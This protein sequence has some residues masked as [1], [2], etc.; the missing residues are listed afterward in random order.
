MLLEPIGVPSNI[1]VK[2]SLT[3]GGMERIE[4]LA[5]ARNALLPTVGASLPRTASTPAP[6]K[7][8]RNLTADTAGTGVNAKAGNNNTV[9]RNWE[10]A[11]SAPVQTFAATDVL[12]INDVFWCPADALRLTWLD[13]DFAAGL[14]FLP[15]GG[16]VGDTGSSGSAPC[17][18]VGPRGRSN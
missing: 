6:T 2:G 3:R 16:I 18:P 11:V 10:H 17:W 14:D 15:V 8:S 9:V 5:A 7:H 1:T 13:A 12:F 4:F